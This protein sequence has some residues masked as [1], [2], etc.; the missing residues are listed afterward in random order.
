VL[1]EL[2]DQR[3]HPARVEGRSRQA[4]EGG[5]D[6]DVGRVATEDA[7]AD[8]RELLDVVGADVPRARLEGHDVA[9][10][11]GRDLLRHH[12]D[13]RPVAIGDGRD[14]AIGERDGRRDQRRLRSAVER[15]EGGT[16]DGADQDPQGD[17]QRAHAQ[18]ADERTADDRGE[19]RPVGTVDQPQQPA[20]QRHQQDAAEDAVPERLQ[21]A[22]AAPG[23]ADRF[24]RRHQHRADD[25]AG[26]RPDPV[27]RIAEHGTRGGAEGRS[28][29]QRVE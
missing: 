22:G 15:Q 28:P 12:P 24:G 18:E 7:A 1:V 19:E 25:G 9:Q 27:D 4:V 6:P 23:A 2:A 5:Q 21:L 14:H 26:A 3:V 20:E 11:R 13:Q 29:H 10:L 8:L 17:L 16:Q